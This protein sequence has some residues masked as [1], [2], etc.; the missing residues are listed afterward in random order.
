MQKASIIN[1]CKLPALSVNDL[2]IVCAA[3]HAYVFGSW[4]KCQ[5]RQ[6]CG[7]EIVFFSNSDPTLTLVSDP[8]SEFDC[9]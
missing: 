1:L 9:L 7:S 3:L 5:C 6:F 8:D 4:V 2:A